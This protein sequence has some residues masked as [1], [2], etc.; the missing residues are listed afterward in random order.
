MVLKYVAPQQTRDGAVEFGF[1]FAVNEGDDVPG[2]PGNTS[3]PTLP[4]SVA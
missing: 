2:L 3:A 4:I 1:H